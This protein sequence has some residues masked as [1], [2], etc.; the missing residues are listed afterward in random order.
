MVS[1][2]KNERGRYYDWLAHAAMEK[3]KESPSYWLSTNDRERKDIY[4]RLCAQIDG[5]SDPDDIYFRSRVLHAHKQAG[6]DLPVFTSARK[7]KRAPRIRS[8]VY[9]AVIHDQPMFVFTERIRLPM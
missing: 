5:A 2:P 3:T 9:S 1:R 4:V 6:F 8:P 7:K